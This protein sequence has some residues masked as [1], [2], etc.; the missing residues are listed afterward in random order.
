M[1]PILQRPFRIGQEGFGNDENTGKHP[2]KETVLMFITQHIC[3]VT[4]FVK[5][6]R[7]FQRV[8]LE[9]NESQTVHF[10][11]TDDDCSYIGADMK[12]HL[13]TGIFIVLVGGLTADFSVNE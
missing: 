11:I 1:F 3:S 5:R 13:G 8:S 9:P 4:P 7:G 6:L 2:G 10:E 12:Q